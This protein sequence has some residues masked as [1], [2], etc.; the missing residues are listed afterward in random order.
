[1][2]ALSGT[3]HGVREAGKRPKASGDEGRR[4]PEWDV[5]DPDLAP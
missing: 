3:H 5:E 2:V 1:M 4:M